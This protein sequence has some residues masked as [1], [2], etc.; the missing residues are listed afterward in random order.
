[1]DE[2]PE[3]SSRAASSAQPNI[4]GRCGELKEDQDEQLAIFKSLA[5]AHHGAFEDLS[6]PPPVK[7]ARG[8]M[9]GCG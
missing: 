3:D 2:P 9:M 4:A 1:M 5:K 7:R 6:S 8:L